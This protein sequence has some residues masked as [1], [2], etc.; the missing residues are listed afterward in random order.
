MPSA[1]KNACRPID[2]PA[3][4]VDPKWTDQ[5]ILVAEPGEKARENETQRSE[6][7]PHALRV[8]APRDSAGRHRDLPRTRLRSGN[9]GPHRRQG[10]G[11]QADRLQPLPEQGRAVQGAHSPSPLRADGPPGPS[12]PP[13]LP[14]PTPPGP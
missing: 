4:S 2:S 3:L 13:D 12:R 9:D 14:P 5:S 1:I 6:T 8:Q 11:L 10:R 7:G